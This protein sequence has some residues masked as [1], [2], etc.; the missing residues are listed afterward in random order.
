M[1]VL[2][3]PRQVNVYNISNTLSEATS[4]TDTFFSS[5]PN[6]QGEGGD[7]PHIFSLIITSIL[8]RLD[9]I[10]RNNKNKLQNIISELKDVK[11]EL[12]KAKNTLFEVS[13][14][15]NNVSF[16]INFNNLSIINEQNIG[17]DE[18]L[19]IY[20]KRILFN[21]AKNIVRDNFNIVNSVLEILEELNIQHKKIIKNIIKKV[22]N[23]SKITNEII[24]NLKEIYANNNPQELDLY[25]DLKNNIENAEKEVK[26]TIVKVESIN[27]LINNY[28]ITRNLY[29]INDNF[30]HIKGAAQNAYNSYEIYTMNIDKIIRNINKK[31]ESTNRFSLNFNFNDENFDKFKKIIKF[32]DLN[33]NDTNDK[34]TDKLIEK[35]DL[36]NTNTNINEKLKEILVQN[37]NNITIEKLKNLKKFKKF[38]KKEEKKLNNV[39]NKDNEEI[40]TAFPLVNDQIQQNN[41][42]FDNLGSSGVEG[43]EKNEENKEGITPIQVGAM[44]ASIVTLSV[45]VAMVT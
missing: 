39:I 17:I 4:T 41:Q 24:I 12:E 37:F 19:K 7:S 10:S 35:L 40:Y 45:G 42:T 18:T 34:I 28:N 20:T 32:I 43:E 33:L 11:N 13:A 26:D 5:V 31:F 3:P 25:I 16:S 14:S 36:N 15:N 22:N 44:L 27:K 8:N 29:I 2:T 6:T 38:K 30:K 9:K 23:I 21:E 1:L